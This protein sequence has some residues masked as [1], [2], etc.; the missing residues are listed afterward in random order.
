MV[1]Q[2]EKNTIDRETNWITVKPLLWSQQFLTVPYLRQAG[3]FYYKNLQ[4]ITV[5]F[6]DLFA[7]F[8]NIQAQHLTLFI[9]LLWVVVL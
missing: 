2:I 3:L 7:Y 9:P 1:C 4:H 8:Q 6:K 5:Q